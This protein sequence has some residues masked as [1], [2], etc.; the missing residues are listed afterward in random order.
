MAACRQYL[1]QRVAC[2][3]RAAG[4]TSSLVHKAKKAN[5]HT[6]MQNY[7]LKTLGLHNMI[8]TLGK[9]ANCRL[10]AQTRGLLLAFGC[11]ACL[12]QNERLRTWKCVPYLRK[13]K[14]KLWL[15]VIKSTIKTQ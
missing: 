13:T 1:R 11:H 9:H 12:P 15:S 14:H 7:Y 2:V 3:P 5:E 10:T 6:V 4:W 8:M